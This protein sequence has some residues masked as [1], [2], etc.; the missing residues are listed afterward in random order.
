MV[1]H[2]WQSLTIAVPSLAPSVLP[3]LGSD[4]TTLTRVG[5]GTASDTKGKSPFEHLGEAWTTVTERRNTH[6]RG[7][8]VTQ[9]K[10]RHT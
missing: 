3:L 10:S 8:L 6:E 1:R 4:I 7:S 9:G 2:P 5:I